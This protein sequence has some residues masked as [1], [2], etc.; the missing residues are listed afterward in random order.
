MRGWIWLVVGMG[1]G[2]IGPA[3]TGQEPAQLPEEHRVVSTCYNPFFKAAD[4]K[5]QKAMLG[6]L[7]EGT[8]Q[9]FEKN[10]FTDPKGAVQNW[11]EFTLAYGSMHISKFVSDVLMD[12]DRAVV[13]DP[14]GG[15][16]KCV[17]EGTEWKVDL[18]P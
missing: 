4:E 17:R 3:C 14:V 9:H 6:V 15:T 1:L 13:K 12:G 7:S 18:T 16:L 2:G 5:D 10:V 8:I 11:E